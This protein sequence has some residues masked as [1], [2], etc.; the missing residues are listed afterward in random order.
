MTPE[1]KE[2]LINNWITLSET[3][4]QALQITAN[5]VILVF[6][7]FERLGLIVDNDTELM[8]DPEFLTK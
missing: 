5:D 2:I 3:L 7:E 6:Q 1:E 4:A 8:C